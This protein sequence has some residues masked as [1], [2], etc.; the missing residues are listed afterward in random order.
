MQRNTPLSVLH[1]SL[2]VALVALSTT[3]PASAGQRGDDILSSTATRTT[4]QRYTKNIFDR[5][6]DRSYSDSMWKEHPSKSSKHSKLPKGGKSGKS[7]SKSGAKSSKSYQPTL[8]RPSGS[9]VISPSVSTSAS[10]SRS[11]SSIPTVRPTRIPSP[12]P[13]EMPHSS[14]PSTTMVPS[15]GTFTHGPTASS[16][17]NEPNSSI[18][19]LVLG[20][21]GTI[22]T[23]GVVLLLV[24]VFV[25]AA[26]RR[27]A[28]TD[29]L[30]GFA[31]PQCPE[32]DLE[33][34]ASAA[35]RL[36]PDPMTE[37]DEDAESSAPSVWSESDAGA[38]DMEIRLHDENEDRDDVAPAGSALAAIGTAWNV[39]VDLMSP[40]PQQ[41][42]SPPSEGCFC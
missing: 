25:L 22:A 3:W 17:L 15:Q 9:S 19:P 8:F 29:R 13:S 26:Y 14:G 42:L 28:E 12:T 35:R 40:P 31:G 18:E 37:R 30:K 24:A 27:S 4:R 34:P 23:S 7:K 20:I 32:V 38:D 5:S 39:A 41:S 21:I 10:P 11:P 1:S 2:L 36:E 16:V 6:S 33:D